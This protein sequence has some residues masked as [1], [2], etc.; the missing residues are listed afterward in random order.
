MRSAS[1]S[2]PFYIRGAFSVRHSQD[3]LLETHALGEGQPC[4]RFH[5]R[6]DALVPIEGRPPPAGSGTQL[7]DLKPAG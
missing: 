3:G 6:S 7:T 1:R 4:L 2:A 5:I